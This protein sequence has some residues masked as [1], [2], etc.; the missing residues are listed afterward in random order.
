[1][2]EFALVLPL[3]L[4]ILAVVFVAA[5]LGYLQISLERAAYEG[6]KIGA[7]VK[8]DRETVARDRAKEVMGAL[9]VEEPEVTLDAVTFPAGTVSVTTSYDWTAPFAFGLP[10]TFRLQARAVATLEP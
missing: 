5:W 4:T 1:M 3:W 7:I 10:S 8:E 6:A 9:A 2:V